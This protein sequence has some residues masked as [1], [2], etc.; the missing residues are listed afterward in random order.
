MEDIA[1]LG[2][3]FLPMSSMTILKTS[4]SKVLGGRT[5]EVAMGLVLA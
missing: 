4:F 3:V 5:P 2:W 1:R